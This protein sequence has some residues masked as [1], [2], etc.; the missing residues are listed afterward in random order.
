MHTPVA[1]VI[2]EALIDLVP[3]GV[4]GDFRARPGGSPFNVAVGLA[5]LGHR[6]SLMARLAD[7]AFGRILHHHALAEGID[8]SSAP[9]AAEPTTL[10]VVTMDEQSQ[11][12]Y[13]FYYKGTADWQW[14][15]DETAHAPGGTALLH[16]GSAAS[17]TP[18]GDGHIHAL[19]SRLRDDDSVLIS[20]DPN[21]RPAMLASPQHARTVVERTVATAHLVKASRE[22]VEWL[23]PD[24]GPEMVGR[25]WLTLGATAVVITDGAQG[26]H[27]FQAGFPSQHRPGRKIAVVDTIGAGDAFTA[28]LLGAL[29]RTGR[30][31]PGSFRQCP[32]AALAAAVDEAILVSAL[33][34]GRLGADPPVARP[35]IGIPA[36]APLDPSELYFK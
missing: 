7:N 8:L 20:Y 15:Q 27:V 9:H 13:D 35:R 26:A 21:V 12:S 31:A 22:D 14:S 24:D 11:A 4:P 33:T 3:N 19:A 34:C 5:R 18:P 30:H 28:G 17:W 1:T 16:L 36:D 32:P 29:I 2:G 10:A 25:R 23:Y 6:T